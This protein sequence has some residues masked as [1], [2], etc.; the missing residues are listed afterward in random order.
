MSLNE[1]SSCFWNEVETA[2]CVRFAGFYLKS[3]TGKMAW[4][5]LHMRLKTDSNC[6]PVDDYLGELQS[7]TNVTVFP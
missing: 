2:D 5:C 7:Q 4:N 1:Q 3:W 6:F